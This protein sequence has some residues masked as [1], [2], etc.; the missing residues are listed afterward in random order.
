MTSLKIWQKGLAIVIIP[1]A[2][3]LI[4]ICAL[5]HSLQQSAALIEKGNREAEVLVEVTN[6]I[7]L[8]NSN[9]LNCVEYV[10]TGGGAS[11]RDEW[12]EN[13]R[14]IINCLSRLKDMTR[15][16]PRLSEILSTFSASLQTRLKENKLFVGQYESQKFKSEMAR[17]LPENY[18]E[19]AA[20][21]LTALIK[22]LG[23]RQKD[24][25]TTLELA[26]TE[27]DRTRTTAGLGLAINVMMA[28]LFGLIFRKNISMRIAA[29][30]RNAR[31]ISDSRQLLIP[32]GGQDELAELDGKL[33]SV[34]ST[35]GQGAKF[36]REFMETMAD[37]IQR[38]LLSCRRTIL[39]ME[40]ADPTPAKLSS[41]DASDKRLHALKMGIDS[42]L[43]LVEDLLLLDNLEYGELKINPISTDIRELVTQAAVVLQ[44][45]ASVRNIELINSVEPTILE[46]DPGRVLQVMNNLLANAIKFSPKSGS[47]HI[48]SAR[49]GSK[50]RISVRDQGPGMEKAVRARIFQKF[51]QSEEGKK[52]GGAGLGLAIAHL[53]VGAHDGIIGV[54][55]SPGQGSTFWFELPIKS[56]VAKG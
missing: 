41:N 30:E 42:S 2:I 26:D 12:H 6:C 29:L 15:N 51:F 4:W 19:S 25:E 14:D 23:D 54:D 55:S 45:L 34:Q 40:S 35:I 17:T 5:Y 32:I 53:I 13:C 39:T 48:E 31:A 33:R 24:F 56:T 46:I 8:L 16:D 27:R 3:N 28:G 47:I 9:F 49:I 36:R 38:P 37:C 7:A 18:L 10:D 20:A 1:F 22:I 21:D 11:A 50:L 52:A 44:S 43:R